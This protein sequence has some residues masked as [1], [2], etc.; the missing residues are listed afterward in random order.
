MG[1]RHRD[2]ARCAPITLSSSTPRPVECRALRFAT[3]RM[4][5]LG[6]SSARTTNASPF[7]ILRRTR[8]GSSIDRPVSKLARLARTVVGAR[9]SAAHACSDTLNASS[10]G[11]WRSVSRSP[12]SGP[13]RARRGE[14]PCQSAHSPSR[15]SSSPCAHVFHQLSRRYS[16]DVMKL[17][18][19]IARQ[20][21]TSEHRSR[22]DRQSATDS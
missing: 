2:P 10:A 15:P 18:E 9:S 5:I 17:G 1:R 4:R 7:P 20:N 22:F 19:R 12:R 3:S 21:C 13:M 11:F 6:W 8:S 16:T 14:V